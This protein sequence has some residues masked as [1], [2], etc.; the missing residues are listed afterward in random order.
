[1][2]RLTLLSCSPL[3]SRTAIHRTGIPIAALDVSPHRTHAVLAGREILK[4]IRVTGDDCAEETNLRATI[5]AY[6]STHK[7]SAGASTAKH[8]DSLAATDVKWASGQF[9]TKIATA[10][11]NG[12]I[13]IYD[14]HRPGLE[15]ARLHEHNRQVHRLAFNPYHPSWLL[16][17]SQD[18]S[19]R[20]W[21]LRTF[22]SERGVVSCRS[23]QRHQ[24]NSDAIRDVRWSPTDGVEFATG[25]DSG[26]IQRWDIRKDN[27][28]V[29]KI[30]AHEKTCHSIDW[31]PDG[32]HLVTGGHDKQVKV[33]DFSSKDRR[34]KPALQFRA[35]QAV[36]NVRWRPA[37]RND[38]TNAED[39]QST[40]VVTSY[41]QEDSRLHLWDLRRPY[42]PYRE[43]DRY[44]TPPTDLLW[45]SKDLLWT[46]GNQGMFT[47]TDIRFSPQ[48]VQ[49]R[50]T[51]TF[52]WNPNGT[53]LSFTQKRPTR[54][55]SDIDDPINFVKGDPVSRS[56]ETEEEIL[57]SSFRKRNFALRGSKSLGGTPPTAE[58]SPI[59]VPF[60]KSLEKAGEFEPAQVG[61]HGAIDAA[62]TDTARLRFLA[63]RYTTI[64]TDPGGKGID[65]TFAN[66]ADCSEAV[67]F[68]RMAQSWRVVGHTIQQDL[69]ARAVQ[70]E[71]TDRPRSASQ[72]ARPDKLKSHLFKGVTE[73]GLTDFESTS[74][75]TTPLAKPLP[76]STDSSPSTRFSSLTD[77]A[78][79]IIDDKDIPNST[80]SDAFLFSGVR[81]ELED[82]IRKQFKQSHAQD[83]DDDYPTPQPASVAQSVVLDAAEAADP[84]NRSAPRAISTKADWRDLPNVEGADFEQQADARRAALKNY[85]AQPKMV[86]SYDERD[87]EQQSQRSAESFSTMFSTSEQS[88][89]LK[90]Q[91]PTETSKALNVSA[92]KAWEA[93]H[94]Q[95]DP[96]SED[97]EPGSPQ[98]DRYDED[99][100]AVESE[101]WSDEHS[102]ISASGIDPHL[103]RPE[104]PYPLISEKVAA[105]TKTANELAKPLPQLAVDLEAGPWSAEDIIEQLVSYHTSLNPDIQFAAHLI[106]TVQP[107]LSDIHALLPRS[108]CLLIF[109]SY[110]DYLIRLGL[111]VEA[112]ALRNSCVPL[113]P[114]IYDY[115]QQE[116]YINIYCFTCRRPYENSKRNNYRCDRCGTSQAPCPICLCRDPPDEWAFA[117]TFEDPKPKKHAAG[118]W[119]WCQGCGHGG[120]TVCMEKWLFDFGM[121]E[122]GCAT[123]GC[124]H[125]CG[126]GPRRRQFLEMMEL[127]RREEQKKKWSG[128]SSIAAGAANRDSWVA[129]ESRAVERVRGMLGTNNT[130]S[131]ENSG[132]REAKTV[133]QGTAPAKAQSQAGQ[134]V[135]SRTGGDS[136]RSFG[137]GLGGGSALAGAGD[138]KKRGT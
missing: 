48:V 11:S 43:F 56:F 129:G 32:K 41:N 92:A 85:Q 79:P 60:I 21:D 8:K 116:T 109:K 20:L 82:E 68:H 67:G 117:T 103:H 59:V 91:S 102:E 39:W 40:Q 78:L 136:P 35:P 66:N 47:Q 12:R 105:Y 115:A 119:A 6:A 88:Q 14:L 131:T 7:T 44:E 96:E 62:T 87:H 24:G 135:G 17:G 106:N 118:I 125:D 26:V 55:V 97:F 33:W 46:V 57:S 120:H 81:D 126:D 34:Q 28:P 101:E 110:N 52:A 72:P 5:I 130:V 54:T 124:W 70:Q 37:S 2:T 128:G 53:I 93:D 42:I 104:K 75:V 127:Q 113:Y 138:A 49:R 99:S 94:K 132:S 98:H 45:F 90:S 134:S 86:L 73:K 108:A 65:D 69:A 16:S 1:M 9:E 137:F 4:T 23:R 95:V 74:N 18:A 50:K 64:S 121:S 13:V 71:N 30:N 51:S 29:M 36:L 100:P 3:P 112:A 25:T 27:A 84:R 76:D 111:D 107:L 123:P 89:L 61:V 77:S 15:Y 58:G 22:P 63:K 38:S 122:G 31:H 80:S 83:E 10:V 19:I 114:E 133:S